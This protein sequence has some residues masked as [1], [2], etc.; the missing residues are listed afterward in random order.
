[1]TIT[2]TGHLYAIWKIS[3]LLQPLIL[4]SFLGI[5]PDNIFKISK[6]RI[7]IMATLLVI[8]SQIFL[9]SQFRSYAHPLYIR[10][11]NIDKKLIGNK[12]FAIIT[13]SQSWVYLR[14]ASVGETFWIN[15]EWWRRFNQPP[16]FKDIKYSSLPIALYFD[17]DAE[18]YARCNAIK[19]YLGPSFTPRTVYPLNIE[20][21]TLLLPNNMIDTSKLNALIYEKFG[22][23]QNGMD[24]AQD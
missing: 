19:N 8:T 2:L 9:I 1:L 10:Q 14:L 5:I 16:I 23:K 20:L 18:G 17:C 15:S 24:W 11:F 3:I 21:G 7:L 4:I 13:P 22:V 12:Q 6:W